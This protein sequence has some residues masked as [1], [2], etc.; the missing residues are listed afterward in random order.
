MKNWSDFF[1]LEEEKDYYKKLKEKITK[2]RKINTIYPPEDNVFKAFELTPLEEL[3]VVIL[4]Q[5]PYHNE[6]QAMGLSFSVPESQKKLPPSL[7][8]IYKELYKTDSLKEIPKSGDLTHWSTQGVFLLNAALTVRKHEPN[9]HSKYGWHNFTDN[10]IK[11]I[12][13]NK[14]GVIFV[15]WGAFAHKKEDLVDKN[16]HYIIKTPHPSPFSARRGFFGSNCFNEVNNKLISENLN[17]IK[18]KK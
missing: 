14:E 5:D 13:D 11:Y 18:W 16:K 10:C 15:L 8:N 12:S 2:E 17:P 3:K 4:G 1:K 7:K 6:N 9:S